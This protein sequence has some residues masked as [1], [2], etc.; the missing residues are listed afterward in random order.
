MNT[1]LLSTETIIIFVA[2]VVLIMAIGFIA[3]RQNNNISDYMLGGRNLGAAVA[4]LG[5]GA[6]DMSG[7]LLLGLPGAAYSFGINQI[8]LPIGLTLGAFINWQ[9]VAKRLR[10]Y[11]EITKD[12]LT[13]PSFLGGRFHDKRRILRF[14][15]ALILLIF[16]TSYVAAGFVSGAKLVTSTLHFSYDTSLWVSAIFIMTYVCIGGF[17][18]VS[19]TDFFQGT[20]MFLA[21][22]AIPIT[23]IYGAGGWEA[24]IN[25]LHT[26]NV[27]SGNDYLN[28]FSNMTWIG[29]ISLL[30]WGLGYFGQAHIL[31]RFMAIKNTHDIPNARFICMTWMI[32]SLY[33]A[34]IAGIVGIIYFQDP[35]FISTQSA[36]D[37]ESV[38]LILATKVFNP[39]L[40]G[41]F[42]AAVLS[43]VMSTIAAQLLVSSSALVEDFYHGFLKKD[44]SQKELVWFG[45][46]MVVVIALIAIY[47]AYH[48]KSNILSLVG[49]AWAGMGAS[50]GPTILFSLFWRR[51]TL[52]GVV[53]SII[54]GAT[55][56]I[57]WK[58][59]N[60]LN[61]SPIF[62]LYE[63][64]PGFFL[65]TFT[66]VFISLLD[67]PA[68][69]EIQTDFDK[70]LARLKK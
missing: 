29:I 17:L 50:F 15:T 3:N 28:A 27:A 67:E 39:W 23:A 7:W 18:A 4:A 47:L 36:I 55:T 53:A 12:A 65:A 56:V 46:I 48:T 70:M 21:L 11:T 6:S 45:R 5:A 52:K 1:T 9:Y 31:V 26:I 57:V 13:I 16:F 49:Y 20:L 32:L 68:N 51:T 22:L 42:L 66:I 58:Y 19:W 2:Y 63:M 34:I 61:L 10:I 41:L 33:G 60:S 8:W 38:L 14:V 25:T 59:C 62:Q 43:A 54:V 64:V 40:V 30:A 44:A 37:P 35:A 24:S 69:A